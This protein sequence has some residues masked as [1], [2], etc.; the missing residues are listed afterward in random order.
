MTIDAPSERLEDRLERLAKLHSDGHLDDEEYRA[1]KA[2]LLDPAQ[3]PHAGAAPHVVTPLG[4]IRWW[5]WLIIA[6][7]IGFC[8]ACLAA[9]VT[10]LQRPAGPVLCRDG[11]F[12]S[13]NVSEHFGGTTAYNIDSACVTDDGVVHH[14]SEWSITGILWVE[15][16]IGA[17][18]VMT[19]LV[20]VIRR[21]RRPGHNS[22]SAG[23]TSF[24]KSA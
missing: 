19:V 22:R 10:T 5:V 9:A 23:S 12:I 24:E 14:L 18:A 21:L 6:V 7:V 1:A 13:G 15:Y 11:Q 8:L 4:P 3:T 20:W 16:T 2:V 17:F